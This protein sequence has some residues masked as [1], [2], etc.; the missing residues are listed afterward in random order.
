M[1]SS[2]PELRQVQRH[3]LVKG[4]EDRLAH[5]L[6][7]PGAV[8][9]EQLPEVPELGHRHVGAPRR[10]EAL[11]AADA[12][13]DVGG[14]DHRH[15]VGAVADGEEDRLLL[16][17]LDQLHHQRLLHGRDAAADDGLAHDGKVEEQLL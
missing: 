3:V 1:S 9:E 13:A 14:L 8:D 10:L 17:L 2:Y 5:A 11:D 4:V 7:A 6:V 16:V 12:H 15:V